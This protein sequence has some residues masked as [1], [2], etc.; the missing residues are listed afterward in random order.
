MDYRYLGKTGLKVAAI[1]LGC[2]TFGHTVEATAAHAML[3]RYAEA[4]GNYFDVAD[5]YGAAEETLGRWLKNKDRRAQWIVASKVRFPAGEGGPNDVGL[6]RKHIFDGVENSPRKLQ[7]QE[8]LA[9]Q[10]SAGEAE[11]R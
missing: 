8:I 11:K 4:G 6:T 1:G 9:R 3:G 5:N 2:M 7:Q 10:I